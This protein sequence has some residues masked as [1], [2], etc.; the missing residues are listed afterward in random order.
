MRVP[1]QVQCPSAVKSDSS[2]PNVSMSF[3]CVLGFV[4]VLESMIV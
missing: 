4:D 1:S 3:R 2:N